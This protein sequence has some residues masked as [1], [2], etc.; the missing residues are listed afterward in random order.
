MISMMFIAVIVVLVV[1]VAVWWSVTTVV[2]R[3]LESMGLLGKGDVQEHEVRLQR[4]EEAIDALAVQ[5][6]RLGRERERPVIPP[7]RERD[8]ELR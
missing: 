4:I 2:P 3:V 1:P 7:S 5:V 8:P 6:E